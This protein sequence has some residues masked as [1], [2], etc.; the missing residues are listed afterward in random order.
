M[1]YDVIVVG[2]GPAGS[3][4]ARECAV[5]GL[6]VLM[7]DKAEFPRDKPCGG[8]VT[9]RA[10]ELLPFD[11]GSVV[12]RKP[13]GMHLSLHRS[14]GFS[15]YADHDLVYMTQRRRFDTLLVDQAIESGVTLRQRTAI[16]SLDRHSSHVVVHTDEGSFEGAV[17]VGADGAN[18]VTAKMAG[19]PLDIVQ[20]IALE[21]NITPQ[22]AFPS[23][24]ENKFGLDVGNLPGGYGWLFP[25]GDHLNIG[26]GAWK[27]YGPNL[28]KDLTLLTQ[29]YGF[30]PDELWGLRGHHLPVRTPSSPLLDGNVLL[31]GDAAGL[32]DPLS[33][34]GIYSAIWSGLT[35]ANHIGKYFAGEVDNLD[36]YQQEVERELIPDLTISRQFHDMFHLSPR[37]F[38]SIEKMTSMMWDLTC[39]VLVGEQ[40]YANVM[41]R[42]RTFETVID[43]VS[44]LIRVTPTLQRRSGLKEPAP[45]Q[46]FFAS[47]T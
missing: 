33:G 4:A 35:A 13:N 18:G 25:K 22:D 30:N 46:R 29:Y 3:T 23:E 37:F 9:I 45:P 6:S 2:A 24:W 41:E 36:G 16:R 27:Y 10:A 32:L 44:D 34:E 28:R 14:R 47:N 38:F 42:H 21:G 31:V 19:I 7:L 5:K 17:I 39:R 12:E 11:L 43:F 26:L 20:G 1:K 40:T 8:G 15:R